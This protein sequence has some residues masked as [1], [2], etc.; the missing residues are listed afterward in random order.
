MDV[1]LVQIHSQW[2]LIFS[3]GNTVQ[4]TETK[5][6]SR[7]FGS[8][9]NYE[10]L[11]T[12]ASRAELIKTQITGALLRFAISWEVGGEQSTMKIT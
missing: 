9:T 8:W 10:M 6:D 11:I 12:S 7:V 3:V 1:H 4:E 5:A 2:W